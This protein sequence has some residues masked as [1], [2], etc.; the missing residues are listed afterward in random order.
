MEIYI[1]IYIYITMINLG[2]DKLNTIV[3]LLSINKIMIANIKKRNKKIKQK[4]HW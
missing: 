3:I 2:Y 1:Y 4:T